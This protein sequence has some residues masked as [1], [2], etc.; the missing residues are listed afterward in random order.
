MKRFTVEIKV[1]VAN[2]DSIRT[3]L[4]KTEAK[5]IGV[6]FQTDIYF[7]VPRGRLKLRQGNIE[8]SLIYYEREDKRGPKSSDIVFQKVLPGHNLLEILGE[9]LGIL[10]EV[11]KEREIYINDHV[12]IHLDKVPH[13]GQFVEIEV[14]TG[15]SP[16]NENELREQCLHFMERLGLSLENTVAESYCDILLAQKA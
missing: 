7:N 2:L 3:E 10:A 4:N 11:K 15:P 1:Q 6:D 14:F 9:S 8:N 16:K 12:K 5:F 13:L